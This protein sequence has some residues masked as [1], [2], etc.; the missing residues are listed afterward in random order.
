MKK[1][2]IIKLVIPKENYNGYD[3]I[4]EKLDENKTL[5]VK[6]QPIEYV[7]PKTKVNIGLQLI[8]IFK[9]YIENHGSLSSE[10]FYWVQRLFCYPC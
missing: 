9:G 5:T 1:L 6:Q 10:R 3:A 4:R 2:K 8:D 7:K